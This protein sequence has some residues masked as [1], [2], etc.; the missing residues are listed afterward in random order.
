VRS[1]CLTSL[2][3]AAYARRA[4]D[5]AREE[6]ALG[7]LA[8]RRNSGEHVVRERDWRLF[9]E[10]TG[11]VSVEVGRAHRPVRIYGVLA[12][13]DAASGNEQACRHH[14]RAAIGLAG[15]LGLG[16]YRERAER[17]LGNLE[18]ALGRLEPAAQLLEGV[19]ERLRGV[20]NL[21]FNV[22]PAWNLAEIYVRLGRG[23]DAH[24]LIDAAAAEAPPV[25]APERAV[26]QRCHGLVSDDFGAV[27]RVGAGIARV[28]RARRD[29]PVRTCRTELCFGERLR[30]RGDR[31]EAR[32]HLRSALAAFDNLG[33]DAWSTR[34]TRSCARAAS[35]C[36]PAG[37]RA[38]S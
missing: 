6:G 13:I 23:D 32:E 12:D 19:L 17:A 25:S 38:S 22:T 5:A 27:V 35:G 14:A 37:I 9:L 3:G 2:A 1:S 34:A 26:V 7:V 11:R 33:A 36:R 21:E 20:G 24:R 30:R 18:L 10:A 8:H 16:F 28:E 4:I 15:E 29:D 31:R